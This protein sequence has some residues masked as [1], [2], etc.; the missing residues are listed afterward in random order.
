MYRHASEPSAEQCVDFNRNAGILPFD[1]NAE[2]KIMLAFFFGLLLEAAL[3]VTALLLANL[4]LKTTITL[5]ALIAFSTQKLDVV[6][7]ALG[8]SGTDLG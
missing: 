3:S 2:H 8:Q 6:D 5:D 1:G 4:G 7:L